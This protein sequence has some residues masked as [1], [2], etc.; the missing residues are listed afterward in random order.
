M[1]FSISLP[2]LDQD[3]FDESGFKAYLARAEEL[4]FEGGWTIEQT[5]GPAP[6]IAP[7]ELLS[8]A[9]AVTKRLRLGV[10][11]LVTSLHDPLQLASAITAVDRLSHGRLDV[12]V[13]PGGSF[14]QFPAF[15]V[16]RSTFIASFTEGLELMK[17]AWSDEPR[18]TFHGRFRDVDDLAISPK[19]VQRP[20]PPIWFGANAP[21]ALARAV[22]HGDAFLGAGSSTTAAFAEAVRTVRREINEQGK[23]AD[24]FRIGKR[25]YLIVDDDSARA[26]DRVQAGLR[27]I[28]GDRAD[29]LGDVAVAGTVEDV[30]H[31]LRAVLDAGAQTIVLNPT[32]ATIAEDR[33]QLERLAADVIPRLS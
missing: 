19:P 14:R 3:G 6:A 22:R 25:V 30:V 9:A 16:D 20:H 7:L 26:R 2:Q 18:I 31:G 13:A 4:G 21:A 11:V 29:Q 1:T 28:Y 12:G 33:E 5:V 32:G 15:G 24:R 27:R 23:D 8:Y 17:A 10:A